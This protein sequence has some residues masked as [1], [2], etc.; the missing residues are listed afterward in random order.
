MPPFFS[1][2]GAGPHPGPPNRPDLGCFWR[3]VSGDLVRIHPQSARATGTVGALEKE[4]FSLGRG[5]ALL[6]CFAA[7]PGFS[8]GFQKEI[9]VQL[10]EKRGL[11]PY[12]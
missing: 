9:E 10:M 12:L 4:P 6:N 8:L 11:V 5:S 1:P 2:T 7:C 3:L